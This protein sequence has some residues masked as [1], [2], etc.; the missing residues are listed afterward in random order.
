MPPNQT[1][2]YR[3]I[4]SEQIA[5]QELQQR[6]ADPDGDALG[7]ARRI[8]HQRRLLTQLWDAANALNQLTPL[9]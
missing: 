9:V 7:L 5:L 3:Q 4:I 6:H 2:I 1:E 8:K